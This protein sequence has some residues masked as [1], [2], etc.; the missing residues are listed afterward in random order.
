MEKISPEFEE[1]IKKE[2]GVRNCEACDGEIGPFDM[3]YGYHPNG[4]YGGGITLCEA[5]NTIYKTLDTK[6]DKEH[7]TF[8]Y[9]RERIIKKIERQP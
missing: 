9:W 1:H 3:A 2:F 8:G 6:F 7:D 4:L 5:C